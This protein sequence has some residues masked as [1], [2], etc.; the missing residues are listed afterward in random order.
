[1]IMKTTRGV[2]WLAA[3]LFA[4]IVAW[5]PSAALAQVTAVTVGVNPTCLDGLVA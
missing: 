2:R 3:C 4:T 1:M 5:P